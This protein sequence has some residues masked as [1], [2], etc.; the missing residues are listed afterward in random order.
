MSTGFGTV[1]AYAD[2]QSIII[3]LDCQT[4]T[5]YTTALY[6]PIVSTPSLVV[7]NDCKI[8]TRVQLTSIAYNLQE[9]KLSIT[10]SLL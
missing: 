2:F 1:L 10:I 9:K 6:V 4:Y 5:A 8:N 7:V 3:Y